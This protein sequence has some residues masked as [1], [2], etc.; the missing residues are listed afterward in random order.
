[1][2]FAFKTDLKFR[3]RNYQILRNALRERPHFAAAGTESIGVK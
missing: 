2:Y 1:M 3:I